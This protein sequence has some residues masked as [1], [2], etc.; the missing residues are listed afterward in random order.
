MKLLSM[1]PLIA[2]DVIVNVGV[3]G[4]VAIAPNLTSR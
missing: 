2:F 3:T 1:I 4:S